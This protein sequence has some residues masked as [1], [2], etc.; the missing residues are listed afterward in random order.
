MIL[1]LSAGD[2]ERF[3]ML[4]CTEQFLFLVVADMVRE[5][6]LRSLTIAWAE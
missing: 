4:S 1:K 3:V 5:K 6:R 2:V